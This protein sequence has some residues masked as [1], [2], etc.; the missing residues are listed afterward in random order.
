MSLSTI[1][2]QVYIFININNFVASVHFT[3]FG[4]NSFT[5]QSVT[6]LVSVTLQPLNRTIDKMSNIS[7]V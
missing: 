2:L 1:Q 7:T 6:L 5:S 4:V 3:N